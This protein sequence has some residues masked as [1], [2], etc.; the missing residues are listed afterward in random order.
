LQLFADATRRIY[1]IDFT[2]APSQ[3]KPIHIACG[4]LVG[5]HLVIERDETL[6]NLGDFEAWCSHPGP[7]IAGCDLPF[8][9]PA[10]LIAWLG[11]P[12]GWA[13]YV[14]LIAQLSPNTFADAL[15]S[16]R[17]AQPSGQPKNAKRQI[18]QLA[19]SISA[20][21]MAYVP[22]GKMFYRAAPI[23]LRS[24]VNL[25]AH[26]P[27]HDPRTCLEVYPAL[28]ARKAIGHTSYK[29]DHG[30]R[31]DARAAILAWIQHPGTQPGSCH[32]W[33]DLTITIT[34]A[35]A[36][37]CIGDPSGDTLDA[38]LACIQAAWAASQ[39]NYALPANRP[40]NEGWIADPAILKP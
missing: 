18:D 17:Q 5:Q 20:M 31:A 1:G 3:R 30:Q 6:T 21:L 39:P 19:G 22:V 36:Q 8:G 29:N 27:N 13:D 35:L 24:G 33:Y 15:A 32:A 37:A 23:L 7:W 10:P 38:V 16:Y 34:P 9:Q 40:S 25:P 12:E 2:S 26:R 11:W 4:Q 14:A 28:V